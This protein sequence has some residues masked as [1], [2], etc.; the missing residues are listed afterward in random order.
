M[1][2]TPPIYK[3]LEVLA[4]QP[5]CKVCRLCE[6]HVGLVYLLDDEVN[7]CQQFKENIV[8]TSEGISYTKRTKDGWCSFFD[9]TT[10]T[11]QIYDIRPLCC[12]VYPLDLVHMQDGIWWVI[13]EGC[14]I[15]QRFIQEHKMDVLISIAFC[16][17][18]LL[19]KNQI[20]NWLMQDKLSQQIEAFCE[21]P[22][23]LLKIK[24]FDN[25]RISDFLRSK[26]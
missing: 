24:R 15:A 16:I 2:E 12:R 22:L 9:I 1:N 6:E 8:T 13:H 5:E 20:Y 19:T 14:P 25:S 21:E 10:N 18:R 7:R 3:A 26:T 17:E 4:D 23:S 11:C